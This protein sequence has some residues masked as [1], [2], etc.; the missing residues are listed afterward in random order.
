M[1]SGC[2][3]DRVYRHNLIRDVVHSAANDRANLATVLEKPG[4]LIPRDPIDEDRPPD[5]DPPDPTNISRRPADVWVPRGPSG[6]PE[7]WD[8]SVTSAFKLGPTLPDASSTS[9]IFSS[10]EFWK[11]AF[12]D[13]A[14]QCSKALLSVGS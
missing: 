8:F 1:A 4:L 6:G 3:G 12:L 9:D 13:T 7:A 2:G 5:P 14:S 11:N 10:V